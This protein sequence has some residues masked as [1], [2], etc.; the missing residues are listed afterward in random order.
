MSYRNKPETM[1]DSSIKKFGLP[2]FVLLL[3][4]KRYDIRPVRKELEKILIV[5]NIC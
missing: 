1:Q 2:P 5:Y 4:E 3:E